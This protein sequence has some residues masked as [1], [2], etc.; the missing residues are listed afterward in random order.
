LG[1]ADHTKLPRTR[2]VDA[3]W[4]L[5]AAATGLDRVNNQVHLANGD[6]VSFDRLLIA[7]GTRLGHGSTRKRLH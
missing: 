3:E 1:E 2:E 4:R 5:G 7:A 6:Q